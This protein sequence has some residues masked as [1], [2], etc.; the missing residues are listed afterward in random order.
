MWDDFS[1]T[2][3]SADYAGLYEGYGTTSDAAASVAST[4]SSILSGWPSEI[5]MLGANT[6]AKLAIM[7]QTV[8]GQSYLEGIRLQTALTQSQL[9]LNTG[10]LLLLFGGAAL[11][12]F[13]LKD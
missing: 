5:L 2:G 13:M 12:M 6:A 11:L 10:T 8:N 9:G 4:G 3:N 7:K 1:L